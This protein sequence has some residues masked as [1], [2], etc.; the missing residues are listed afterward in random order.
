MVPRAAISLATILLTQ[1][2]PSIVLC[3]PV[4]CFEYF[5]DQ[6]IAIDSSEYVFFATFSS[7]IE[8]QIIVEV[9]NLLP[10]AGRPRLDLSL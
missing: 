4:A 8:A 7:L 2:Q 3:S 1:V 10:N 5:E 6:L 9:D